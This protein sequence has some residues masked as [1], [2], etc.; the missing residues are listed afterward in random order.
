MREID[1]TAEGDGLKIGKFN[2][3]DFFGDGSFY[4][5][6][7]PGHAVGHL[8]GLARTTSDP[9]TFVFMGGDLCHHGG[10]LRPSENSPLPTSIDV[11]L[12]KAA[13]QSRPCPGG[14]TFQELNV[15]RGRKP[16]EPFFVPAMGLDIPLAIKTIKESQDFDASDNVFFIWAHEQNIGGIVDHFPQSINDWKKKRWAEKTHWAFL[17][18]FV[19]A[20][21]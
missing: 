4:L 16:N 17:R 8:A 14:A 7:T 21:K 9:D 3:V 11:D 2:A 18:D 13:F 12:V 1:F 6:D 5:L 19:D 20:I 10:E 15:K